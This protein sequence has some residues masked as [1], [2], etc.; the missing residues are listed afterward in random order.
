MSVLWWAQTVLTI[1]EIIG[2]FWG[3][4]QIIREHAENFGK[5]ILPIAVGLLTGL[6]IYQRTVLMYSRW[7]LAIT[8][9]YCGILDLTCYKDKRMLIWTFQAIFFET[10]YC[11]DIFLYIVFKIYRGEQDFLTDQFT[12]GAS[13]ITIFL[14]TRG[15]IAAGLFFMYKNRMKT[16]QF[17]K[18]GG[19]LWIVIVAIEHISLII[20]DSIFL[21]GREEKSIDH[22][23]ILMLV[24]PVLIIALVL[25]FMVQRYH[26]MYAQIKE[27]NVLFVSRCQ[28]MEKEDRNR[29]RV[30]HDLRNHLIVLQQMISNGDVDRAQ[31]YLKELLQIEEKTEIRLGAP[32]L[33]YLIQV[34]VSEAVL[35]NIDIQEQYEGSLKELDVEELTDWCA[36]LGNLWDNALEGCER[37]HDKRWIRFSFR[38]EEK[39]IAVKMENSCISDID[40][41]R[42][43]TVKSDQNMHGI[44]LKNIEYVVNK[45]DGIL[46]LKCEDGVFTM[47][48][49]III[50]NCE[51][52]SQS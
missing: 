13:R 35:R 20:C 36:L 32:V 21:P 50:G 47:K 2:V 24:Y 3:I 6:T 4:K 28:M 12:L 51:T 48:I 15:I 7:W 29:K 22:W 23:K 44:G 41:K 14:I 33:D 8:I 30:Y 42:L 1:A 25:L 46:K 37:V 16:V 45:Y 17:L 39:A 5:W 27:Q 34:K 18:D 11:M 10:L 31:G 26:F 19:M 49:L 9:L 52:S 40:S 43:L 38:Q